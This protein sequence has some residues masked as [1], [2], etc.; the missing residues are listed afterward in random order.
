MPETI[1][2]EVCPYGDTRIEALEYDV[3]LKAGYIAP[4][5]HQRVLE[6]DDYPAHHVIAAFCGD[7]LAGS[8][9]VVIDSRPRKGLFSLHCF[10]PFAVWP[11][12]ETLLRSVPAGSM[13]QIGTMVV[14]E[15]FRGGPV[16]Q[17]LLGRL[18][19]TLVQARIQF[20]VAA[21]DER[22][23][24]GLNT[25]KVPLVPMGPALHY[26][27]SRTVP[28][29]AARDWVTSGVVPRHIQNLVQAGAAE[30]SAFET[31]ACSA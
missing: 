8:V 10:E 4:N 16:C 3:Y 11:W 18:I 23:L 30:V 27:G 24:M 25:R 17:A 31:A 20:A 5:P 7:I 6:N 15:D 28:V 29:I 9:R 1:R 22:F 13:M 14:R 12:A 19:E 26:M 2:L 21:I